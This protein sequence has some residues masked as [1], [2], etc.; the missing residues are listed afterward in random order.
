MDPTKKHYILTE[1]ELTTIMA[2]TYLA[3]MQRRFPLALGTDAER[4]ICGAFIRAN[5]IGESDETQREQLTTTIATGR[6]RHANLVQALQGP[7]TLAD[8]FESL[9]GPMPS[10]NQGGTP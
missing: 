1:A 8:L 3:G 2:C 4:V 5:Q 6:E 10:P 9:F 7:R